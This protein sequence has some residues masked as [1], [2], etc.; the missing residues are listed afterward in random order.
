MLR[1]EHLRKSFRGK[2]VLKDINL[3]IKE[4]E[5]ATIIGPSGTGKTTLLRCINFLEHADAG[6]IQLDDIV[7]NCQKATNKDILA[8]CRHSGMVFQ[9]YNLFKNRT[10][11]ENVM[12]GLV[13]VKKLPKE[14]A[15][16]KA[17]QE[18]EK[19]GMTEFINAYPIQLSGGQQQRVAIA[20]ALA[21]E[22]SILLLDEPTS[23]LDPELTKEVLATIAQIAHA[24]IALLIV[25]HEFEFARKISDRIIF[26]ENGFIVE[27]GTP[28][29]I[30]EHPQEARTKQFVRSLAG[31]LVFYADAI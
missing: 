22:P 10:V 3:T 4:G 18:L 7:V 9:S 1:I 11:L 21:M 24:G 12:E 25:T 13:I 16:T 31:D 2:D 23:A 28:Q 26:M 29:Q 15:R 30:F 19:V 8:L 5:V 27:E 6:Q 14:E 17:L 20:R